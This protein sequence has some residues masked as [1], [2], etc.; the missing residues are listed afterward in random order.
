MP[1]N[2]KFN[3]KGHEILDPTPIALPVGMSKPESLESKMRRFIRTEFSRQAQDQG[4]ESF[5][6]ANDF[7][8]DDEADLPLTRYEAHE[9]IDE[10]PTDEQP[11]RSG[12]HHN[13]DASGTTG[14]AVSDFS[15]QRSPQS[16]EHG[17]GD[18][19]ETQA[20]DLRAGKPVRK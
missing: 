18:P 13:A 3:D 16:E 2:A 6:E 7:D 10:E 15:G 12:N 11:G 1:I 17:P 9:L 20:E 4:M 8:M 19:G 14:P 5:D